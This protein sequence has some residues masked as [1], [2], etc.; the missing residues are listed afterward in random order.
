VVLGS[1]EGEPKVFAWA[2]MLSRSHP[3]GDS[4]P[5]TAACPTSCRRRGAVLPPP[6]SALTF[7]P[8]THPLPAFFVALHATTSP[9]CALLPVDFNAFIFCY[10]QI[11]LCFPEVTT[12]N[13]DRHLPFGG[14]FRGLIFVR[15]NHDLL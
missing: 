4:C 2:I 14:T 5:D 1:P 11:L 7:H 15:R 12:K 10:L 3:R 13:K 6:T 9:A 8:G